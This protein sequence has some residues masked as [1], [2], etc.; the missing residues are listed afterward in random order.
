MTRRR[1]PDSRMVFVVL[2]SV[3]ALVPAAMVLQTACA[4]LTEDAQAAGHGAAGASAAEA[5]GI[6]LPKDSPKWRWLSIEPAR[7][8]EEKLVAVLPAQVSMDEDH[9]VRVASPVTGRIVRLDVQPGDH[10]AAGQALAHLTSSDVG[11][12]QSDVAKAEALE[13]QSQASL[14]RAH[15]LWAHQV[16]AQ[17]ELEQAEADA[18]QARA[19]ASRARARAKA[20]GT[21]SRVDQEFVLRA[22]IAGEVLE[23]NA[24]PGAEVR[25]DA[26]GPLFVISDRRR[27]WI[28]AELYPRDLAR[29]HLGDRVRFTTEAAPGRTFDARVTYVSGGLDPQT[30]TAT[31]RASLENA[32][33]VLR[34]QTPGSVRLY[35]A[36]PDPAPVVPTA[37]LITNGGATEVIVQGRDGRFRR[38]AVLVGE[39]DGEQSVLTAGL[40]PGERVVTRGSL[41]LAAELAKGE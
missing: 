7:T 25:P 15:E 36:G 35:A 18:A 11:Q 13:L 1:R 5:Q 12:A 29:V 24:N 40:S 2:A 22:P 38:R 31:M 34:A 41:L 19:E 4:P 28:T 20:L 33:G 17:K 37:A 26:S 30:R 32:D 23:R 39:D 3:S 21:T 8:R 14:A 27:V 9:S 10:V 6:A 16:I